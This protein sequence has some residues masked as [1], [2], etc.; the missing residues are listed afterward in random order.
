ME[1]LTE[2]AP[3]VDESGHPK[4]IEGDDLAQ[5]E[6]AVAEAPSTSSGSH[7]GGSHDVEHRLRLDDPGQWESEQ[8]GGRDV[9]ER[10]VIR[11][12]HGEG[13]GAVLQRLR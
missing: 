13:P 9:R 11:E 6:A 1:H 4:P 3:G 7:G 10:R 5:F 12:S 2:V 8:Q